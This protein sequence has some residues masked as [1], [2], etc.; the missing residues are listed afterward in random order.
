MNLAIINKNTLGRDGCFIFLLL[1]TNHVSAQTYTPGNTYFDPA[2]HVEYLAGN[3]PIILS[4]PHGGG[5][6]PD[7]IPDREC[8]GCVSVRDGYTKGITQDIKDALYAKTGC[9]P[10]MIINLLH[11]RKFDANRDISDAA[12]GNA[13]VEKA[14]HYYHKVTDSAKAKVTRDYGKGLYLDIHG[15]AHP[16][17]RLEIGNGIWKS[18]LQK[19]DAHLNGSNAL[20]KSSIRNLAADNIKNASHAQ[21]IRGEFSFGTLMDAS[22]YPSVP[23]ST[24]SFPLDTQYFFSGGYNTLRHGSRDAG[25]I[26]AIQVECNSSWRFESEVARKMFS[27]SIAEVIINYIDIHYFTDFEEKYCNF[28]ATIEGKPLKPRFT[29]SPN[30]AQSEV[31]ITTDLKNIAITI[32][33][34]MGK[35]LLNQQW[36]GK[37]IDI[38]IL[39]NGLYFIVISTSDNQKYSKIIIKQ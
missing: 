18:D 39:P 29:V 32:Y 25:T 31:T 38:R 26:D 4:S 20:E 35:E 21:L 10:H 22:G 7:S 3:L 13:Q 19:S 16:L 37:P 6:L 12:D 17:Q 36:E 15:H 34:N 28:S 8:D 23:S 24:D 1:F 2:N 11:R 5:E 9:Y 14:W 33:N 30:P 27:D